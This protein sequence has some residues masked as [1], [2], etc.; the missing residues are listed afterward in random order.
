MEGAILIGTALG[1][2]EG[3]GMLVSKGVDLYIYIYRHTTKGGRK[4]VLVSKGYIGTIQRWRTR[5]R[6]DTGL[7]EVDR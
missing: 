5:T 4:G 6:R 2:G 1:G 3:E 7:K